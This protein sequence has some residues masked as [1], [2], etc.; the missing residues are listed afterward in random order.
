MPSTHALGA[1]RLFVSGCPPFQQP[2]GESRDQANGAGLASSAGAG[3]RARQMT[4]RTCAI[5]D[6]PVRSIECHKTQCCTYL[7]ST[8]FGT[9]P[10]EVLELRQLVPKIPK[11]KKEK[12]RYLGRLTSIDPTVPV[13][14]RP[15]I[16]SVCIE[17]ASYMYAPLLQ[18]PQRRNPDE[19]LHM[20]S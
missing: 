3:R 1:H 2:F 11:R 15:R 17:I 12:T 18:R 19:W 4:G 20:Q 10:S 9:C 6:G 16:R 7:V 14:C 5:P 8:P 13:N